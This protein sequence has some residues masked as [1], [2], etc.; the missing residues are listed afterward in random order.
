MPVI[1]GKKVKIF[2]LSANYELAEK[3]AKTVGCELGK[4]EVQRFAD[5]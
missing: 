3:I 5:G 2:S 4:C 1:E